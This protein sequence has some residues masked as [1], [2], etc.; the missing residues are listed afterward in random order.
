MIQ[1]DFGD[2]AGGIVEFRD[3][4]GLE[5]Y[6]QK[7]EA[8]WAS[9]PAYLALH[10]QRSNEA[11][12]VDKVQ[13]NW[14][15]ARNFVRSQRAGGVSDE[16]VAITLWNQLRESG[17]ISTSSSQGKEIISILEEGQYEAAAGAVQFQ[18]SKPGENV[19]GQMPKGRQLGALRLW[20]T[21]E[22][23]FGKAGASA[24]TIF[25]RSLEDMQTRVSEHRAELEAFEAR[26]AQQLHEFE[27]GLQNRLDE[28]EELK[29]KISEESVADRGSRAAEWEEQRALYLEQLKLKAA[30]QQ[31]QERADQHRIAFTTQRKWAIGVGTVGLGLA[32]LF[33]WGALA[34]ARQI[35]ENFATS[36]ISPG[37]GV[38][39]ATWLPELIFSASASLLYLTLFLWVM[40]IMV[41]SLMAEQHLATD[42][43]ARASMAHT[44]LALKEEGAV[45]DT[46]RAIVLAS[47]FR[48]VR[49]GIVAD[50]ALPLVSPA[51][52]LS[53]QLA[54]GQK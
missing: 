17:V 20:A 42:A 41:R 46:D 47:L 35:F 51:T 49:D 14:A 9:Q 18:L 34:L 22:G 52:I 25:K 11:R 32:L 48:P 5:E 53:A 26:Q 16:Q 7:E 39:R 23:L 2:A 27:Q 30:V 28:I 31:W 6:L 29:Q 24:R 44:Y 37:T 1:V 36:K 45:S 10:K 3:G 4:D 54:S 40:R 21:S 15:A 50:D 38:L 13:T 43:S 12:A 19:L 33:S 8:A